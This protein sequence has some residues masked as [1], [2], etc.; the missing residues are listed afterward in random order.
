MVMIVVKEQ[1][2][3]TQKA[4]YNRFIKHR[5]F[6]VGHQMAVLILAMESKILARWQGPLKVVYKV[7]EVNYKVPQ[8]SKSLTKTTSCTD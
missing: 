7:G 3:K 8:G 4:E 1:L 6:Q 5:Q 2:Q